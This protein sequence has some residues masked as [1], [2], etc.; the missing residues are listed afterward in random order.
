MHLRVLY[1]SLFAYCLVLSCVHPVCAT[2]TGALE[3][4]TTIGPLSGMGFDEHGA[5][6]A[7]NIDSLARYAAGPAVSDMQEL[8]RA[9]DA[10]HRMQRVHLV[11]LLGF[12]VLFAA[13]L[14]VRARTH[15]H[16]QMEQLRSRLSRDLHDDIGS[17]LSSINILSTVAR[18][19]AEAGD[20]VGAA[21]SLRG[22]SERTQRLMRNMSDI[23][24]SVDP[25]RDTLE[26]LLARMREFGAAVLEPKGMDLRFEARGDLEGT[27]P[28][29]LK[30]NLYLIYK[31]AVNNVAKHA[32]A[33]EVAVSFIHANNRLHM[34]ITDNGKA[35]EADPGAGSAGGGN[36]LRNM[37]MRAL[38]LKADLR[39][40]G[41]SPQGTRIDLVLNL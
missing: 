39:I 5:A 23:V 28:P 11:V 16:M 15:R 30:S 41:P 18:R 29:A 33:T 20:D 3:C 37:R 1:H 2:G 10:E 27:L 14:F 34:T 24:W 19:K 26:E 6:D 13:Q 38:E 36:G 12:V 7:L 21:A 4:F 35:M 25:E 9:N 8:L 17:T 40:E 22:I 31:E 32:E